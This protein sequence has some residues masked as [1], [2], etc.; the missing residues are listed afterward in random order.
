MPKQDFTLE[1][2]D[3]INSAL[4]YYLTVVEDEYDESGLDFD[5]DYESSPAYIKMD[6]QRR[7][8]E[9]IQ[10]IVLKKLNNKGENK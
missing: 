8:I 9:A 7:E 6:K 2:L 4:A 5:E 1:Q 10:R 3:F